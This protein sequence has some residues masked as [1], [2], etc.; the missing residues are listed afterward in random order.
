[1]ASNRPLLASSTTD[2]SIQ[3][4]KSSQSAEKKDTSKAKEEEEQKKHELTRRSFRLSDFS[5]WSYLACGGQGSV[6]RAVLKKTKQPVAVKKLDLL[7]IAE[8]PSWRNKS[9]QNVYKPKKNQTLL[10]VKI[11]VTEKRFKRHLREYDLHTC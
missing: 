11:Q 1:M 10:D 2:S 4:T 8:N 9:Y 3:Q 5:E 7:A 6:Y